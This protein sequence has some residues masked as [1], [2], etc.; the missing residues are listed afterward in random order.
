MIIT[1][2]NHIS[3]C[4]IFLILLVLVSCAQTNNSLLR[5][6]DSP[7]NT[8]AIQILREYSIQSISYESFSDDMGLKD[9]PL[10]KSVG[11]SELLGNFSSQDTLF[12]STEIPFSALVSEKTV[13]DS[14]GRT[15]FCQ[16][17]ELD[18]TACPLIAF[19]E[20]PLQLDDYVAKVEIK[21]GKF[22]SY[23]RKGEILSECNS[24]IPNME[25]YVREIQR[26]IDIAEEENSTSTKGSFSRDVNWLR[27][28]LASNYQTKNSLLIAP[29]RIIEQSDGRIILEQSYCAT[30]ST[31]SYKTRV[32]FSP[33]I[34]RVYSYEKE[35]DDI[36]IERRHMFYVD[37]DEA[38]CLLLH[39]KRNA[40]MDYPCQI[41]T[42]Q[43]INTTP[44]TILLTDQ[45][46]ITN[47]I[48]VYVNNTK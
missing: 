42:F 46:F 25:D 12:T 27:N 14:Q 32:V 15:A 6:E 17:I 3:P 33:D 30:K 16:E 19:Y 44:N 7:E 39:G 5:E 43:R 36:I 11:S 24:E 45:E 20:E 31:P 41:V 38:N 18:T 13:I 40:R 23:N 1:T 8:I 29:Y 26:L 4:F 22:R 21:D 47:K 35:Q 28:R 37:N 48:E 34:S 10:T 2:D 9:Y